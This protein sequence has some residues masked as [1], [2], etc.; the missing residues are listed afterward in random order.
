V[1]GK[2]GDGAEKRRRVGDA[3]GGGG[4]G[5]RVQGPSC[6]GVSASTSQY[7]ARTA[8]TSR[9]GRLTEVAQRAG[10]VQI[11]AR[12]TGLPERAS[13]TD[14]GFVEHQRRKERALRQRRTRRGR[15][16]R[17]AS[18]AASSRRRGDRRTRIRSNE[19]RTPS[20]PRC[21]RPRAHLQVH[22]SPRSRHSRR[23]PPTFL[24]SRAN[25]PPRAEVLL[26]S[27]PLLS[28]H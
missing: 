15:P 11:E 12:P 6:T 2:E 20:L 26:L 28:C 5:R 23:I 8:G 25:S 10:L 9:R 16:S 17:A 22:P 1:E 27:D 14:E 21:V 18:R 19:C 7:A 3:E 24:H 4:G 13:C